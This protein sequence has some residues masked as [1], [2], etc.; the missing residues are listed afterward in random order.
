MFSQMYRLFY[1]PRSSHVFAGFVHRLYIYVVRRLCHS[2]VLHIFR[3]QFLPF[4]ASKTCN[5]L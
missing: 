1:M 2:L 4:A 5:R 3:R